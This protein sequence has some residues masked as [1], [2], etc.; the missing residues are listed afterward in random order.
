[1]SPKQALDLWNTERVISKGPASR[2][3]RKQAR[4]RI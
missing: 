2:S 4:S 1:V 3:P